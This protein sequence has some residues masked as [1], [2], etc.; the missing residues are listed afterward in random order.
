MTSNTLSP[1]FRNRYLIR[2]RLRLTSDLHVGDGNERSRR[3]PRGAEDQTAQVA[4]VARALDGQ[5][6]LPGAALKGVLRSYLEHLVPGLDPQQLA[7]IFGWIPAQAPGEDEPDASYGA[8]GRVDVH[9]AL[10]VSAAELSTVTSVGIDRVTRL[11][12]DRILFAQDVV[13]AGTE[14]DVSLTGYDLDETAGDL[15]LLLLAL[16]GFQDEH[17]PIRLGGGSADHQGRAT[18][19]LWRVDQLDVSRVQD[20]LGQPRATQPFA[21]AA[22]WDAA[23]LKSKVAAAGKRRKKSFPRRRPKLSLTLRLHFRGPFLVDDPEQAQAATGGPNTPDHTPRLTPDRRPLLP[24]SSFRG[25]FRSQ[26]ERIARTLDPRAVGDPH[27]TLADRA[28]RQL[29][30]LE[31]L[32]GAAGRAAAIECESFV[33]TESVKGKLPCQQFVAIDRF[34]GGSAEQK[35][36]NA[37]YIWKPT[38]E[39]R[40]HLRLDVVPPW[41]AGLL[42]LT[43]RD[44]VEGDISFG[45]GAAKGYGACTA[46]IVDVAIQ[47]L[48]TLLSQSE[49]GSYG[50]LLRG[51]LVQDAPGVPGTDAARVAAVLRAENYRSLV[52]RSFVNSCTRL[53]REHKDQ[54][55]LP[56]ARSS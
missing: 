51:A 7:R 45:F 11:P 23:V 28:P 34:T 26:A 55:H 54:L 3:S 52:V 15:D 22:P 12:A 30:P 14:F 47:G 37:T 33:G 50:D 5:P 46:Q 10:P 4:T 16:E 40:V 24:A 39:G 44:L 17:E 32:F 38:L 19:T 31:Q 35:L 36:Y 9:Y 18:W 56:T 27:R 6:V 41:L 13:P 25:A 20:W 21:A 29:Y 48:E 43:F 49:P 2:G 1:A 42:A 8:G 53:L